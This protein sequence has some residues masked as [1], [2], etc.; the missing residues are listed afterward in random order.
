MINGQEKYAYNDSMNRSIGKNPFE[1]IYGYH[2]RGILELRGKRDMEKRSSLGENFVSILNIY[3][4]RLN[5]LYK[6]VWK[7]TRRK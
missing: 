6:R 3:M 1:I 5:K 4:S 7:S 2:P